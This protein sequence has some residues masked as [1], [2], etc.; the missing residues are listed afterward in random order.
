MRRRDRTFDPF[1]ESPV[2]GVIAA[3]C[4]VQV[5]FFISLVP[6]QFGSLSV[7]NI[8]IDSCSINM[9]YWLTSVK[10]FAYLTIL[11]SFLLVMVSILRFSAILT[12]WIFYIKI[13]MNA[14]L[15]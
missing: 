6:Y 13:K 7:W 12:I 1:S 5:W 10:I 9:K 15:N 3:H 11:S 2:D 4:S 14:E 8:S